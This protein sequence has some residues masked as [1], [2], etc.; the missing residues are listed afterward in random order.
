MDGLQRLL[1]LV[2]FAASEETRIS[3]GLSGP[4]LLLESLEKL[5]E[6]NTLQFK[7]LP[8]DIRSTLEDRPLK[9]IVLNDKSDL[10]VRFDLF[11]RLNTGGIALSD[12]EVRECVYRGEFMDLLGELAREEDFQTVVRL[13]SQKWK[14]GTPEDYALRF[15]AFLE[16]YQD[17]DH[18]VK[19]FLN[20]FVK[21]AAAEP[22]L[23]SRSRIFRRTFRFLAKAFPAGI[24]SRKGTTAVNL[25]EG[26]SVG[27]ALALQANPRLAAPIQAD[28]LRSDSLRKM[29]TGATN[30]NPRVIGRIEYCRDRFLGRAEDD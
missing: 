25:Y 22:L 26:V 30:S 15:F 18:S 20:D 17:F 8:G 14:D 10:Q 3:V 1:T 2:N 16:R 21:D 4:P 7:D 9:V 12:Q 27:A 24:K 23:D 11:E 6:I 29:S 13:P 28:W 5:S 19:N